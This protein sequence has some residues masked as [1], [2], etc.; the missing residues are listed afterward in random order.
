[1]KIPFITEDVEN[2]VKKCGFREYADKF[3]FIKDAFEN[4]YVNYIYYYL[5]III[6][7]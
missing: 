2:D 3:T 6:I 1:M 5:Y 7:I 4:Q